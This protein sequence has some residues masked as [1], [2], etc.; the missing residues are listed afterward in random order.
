MDEGAGWKT[1]GM[2][3]GEGDRGRKR[4]A[5]REGME[6]GERTG[7]TGDAEGK[8]RGNRAPTVITK[9]RRL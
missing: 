5:G 3:T 7:K 4:G 1:G 6:G 2:G 8:W 9:S